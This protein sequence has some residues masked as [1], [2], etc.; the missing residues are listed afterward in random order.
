[1]TKPTTIKATD[2][3]VSHK[4]A[5]PVQPDQGDSPVF[6]AGVKAL[7]A[8]TAVAAVASDFVPVVL[9][10]AVFTGLLTVLALVAAF[11]QTVKF[12][13]QYDAAADDDSLWLMGATNPASPF[14]YLRPDEYS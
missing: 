14:Y 2:P 13:N 1:M 7:A 12:D 9:G 6:T 11:M 10:I 4:V 3:V 8:I 5:I